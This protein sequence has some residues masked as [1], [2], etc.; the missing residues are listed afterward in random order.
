[1]REGRQEALEGW[2]ESEPATPV[3]DDEA[4]MIRYR[5]GDAAAFDALYQRHRG[6]LYRYLLRQAGNREIAEELFQDVW[7]N[8]I[9]NRKR[10][11]PTARFTTYLYRMAHNRFIDHCRRTKSRDVVSQNP[12]ELT[13]PAP[14]PDET[15]SIEETRKRFLGAV[16]R[17]PES[18]REVFLLRQ[19]TGL[20]TEEIARITGVNA[21][22]TKSRLRYAMNRL[23]QSLRS[24]A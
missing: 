17:L 14:R 3:P 8:L 4:L 6:G 5:E 1:M 21:E 13:D 18:Q 12:P 20:G 19:E 10:Y 2:P 24:S 15:L 9:R 11:Q 22:T 23:K 7:M 16:E